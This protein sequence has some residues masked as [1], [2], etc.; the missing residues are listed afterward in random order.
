MPL[1]LLI[2]ALVILVIG[3]V[4]LF[5]GIYS[6]TTYYSLVKLGEASGRQLGRYVLFRIGLMVGFFL[7]GYFI[8]FGGS[9]ITSFLAGIVGFYISGLVIAGPRVYVKRE[10]RRSPL[11]MGGTTE[12]S[13]KAL[14]ERWLNAPPQS[15]IFI[16][17]RRS[18][19]K[20]IARAIFE[21]V[22]RRGYN[23]FMDVESID[24]GEFEKIIL[25]QIAARAHFLVILTHGAVERCADPEDWLRR[26]IEYAIDLER[27]IVPILV[28]DFSF[29]GTEKYLVGKLSRLQDYNA[30]TLHHDYFDEAMNRLHTRFLRQPV[31]GKILTP[32]ASE[33]DIVRQKMTEIA[34]APQPTEA[35]LNAEGYME[36]G[37]RH[38]AKGETEKAILNY[39]KALEIDSTIALV[40]YNRGMAYYDER[41]LREAFA[42]FSKSIELDPEFARAYFHRG[43]INQQG[44]RL[45][46]ALTDYRQYLEMGGGRQYNDQ[47][48]V[49]R[50]INEL[51]QQ[52]QSQ[53]Q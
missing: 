38:Y 35:E 6:F 20:F 32:S 16:S 42:D 8:L 29:E 31:Y 15:S 47:I 7:I 28:E 49:E 36:R 1:G 24:S 27:N 39:N 5:N 13:R 12:E 48:D 23:V 50:L 52:I 44:K 33:S 11:E 19:S 53:P 43:Q 10:R 37:N 2:P 34:S 18:T 22:R 4:V 17:Y 30:L 3:L 26:E 40:Y 46:R 25:N 41:K 14:N 51:K 45:Q 21:D 9:I